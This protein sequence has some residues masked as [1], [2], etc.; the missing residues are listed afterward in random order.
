MHNEKFW[1]INKMEYNILTNIHIY[2]YH[3]I[4]NTHTFRVPRTAHTTQQI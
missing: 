1:C 4:C 2:I 3:I